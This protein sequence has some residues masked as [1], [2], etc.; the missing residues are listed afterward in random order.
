MKFDVCIPCFY[1]NVSFAEAIERVGNL[2]FKAVETWSIDDDFDIKGVNEAMGRSGVSFFS[3]VPKESG[4]TTEETH[5][6]WLEELK[7]CGELAKKL[8]IHKMITQVGKDTGEDRILQHERIVRCLKKA[9]PILETYDLTVML[10]PL[11]RHDHE[12]Y[13]LTGSLETAQIVREVG[14]PCVRMV[15]DIY[16]QQISEGDV[17]FHLEK[18]LDTIAHIHV[19]AVPGRIE[20]WIGENDCRFI[21]EK[22]KSMGYEGFVGL[23]YFPTLE[24]EESLKAFLQHYGDL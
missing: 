7:R 1:R 19:A 23:E 15:F 22:L 17:I 18:C 5:D 9:V 3:I 24:G 11:N 12:G 8:G 4:L 21:F 13:Y 20:P 2:G 10:E 14:S 16:H 6:A